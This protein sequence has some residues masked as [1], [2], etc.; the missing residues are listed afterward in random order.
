M[1]KLFLE[2]EFQTKG[3]KP[4]EKHILSAK[5]TDSEIKII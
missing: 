1:A 5:S 4:M 2:L 3:N